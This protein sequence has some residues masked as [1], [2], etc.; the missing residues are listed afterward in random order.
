MS[1]AHNGG[2]PAKKKKINPVSS[3]I[4]QNALKDALKKHIEIAQKRPISDT[5]ALNSTIEEFLSTFML[6]GYTFDGEPIILV[7]AKTQ[8][9]SDSLSTAFGRYFIKSSMQ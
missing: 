4:F 3:E 7:N 9:D 8:K 6:I 5:D 2:K 1:E